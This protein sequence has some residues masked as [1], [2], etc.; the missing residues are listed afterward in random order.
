MV[1]QLTNSTREALL[2]A[3]EQLVRTRGYSAFS[4]ADLATSVGI[5]KASIHHHF[6]GK[7]D[8]GC[9][10]VDEYVARFARVCATIDADHAS[11]TTRLTAYA[12][13]YADSV[14]SGMLC[15]CGM[16]ATELSVLPEDVAERVRGFVA[17]QFNWL[18][19]VV[20]A[21]Q[22]QGEL[23]T[24]RTAKQLAEYVLA[25]LQGAMLLGWTTRDPKVISRTI[26]ECLYAARV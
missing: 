8:L 19:T 17:A 22:A 25:S 6:P 21:G 16:L 5:R 12:A 18:Q 24:R 4:Y 9:A 15:L 7:S 10:L 13:V 11:A 23:S 14:R 1:A 2:A 20:A 26:A 3:A